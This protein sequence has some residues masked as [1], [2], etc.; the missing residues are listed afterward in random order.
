MGQ[1]VFAMLEGV[2]SKESGQLWLYGAVHKV[3]HARGRGSPSR[4]DS[5]WQGRG[6]AHV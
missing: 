5:L 2:C 1:I 3:R 4:C 6:Q